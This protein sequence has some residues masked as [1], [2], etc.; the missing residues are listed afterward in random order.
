MRAY[1]QGVALWGPGLP[2]W[3]ASLP[4]LAGTEPYVARSAPPPVPTILSPTERRRTGVPVRLALVAAGQA[5]EMAGVPPG[6]IR[7][8]FA[9][10]NGDG[11]VVHAILEALS[12]PQG[13]VSPTQFHNSVHNAAAGYWTIATSSREAATCLGCHDATFAAALL[14]ALAE[15]ACERE[16]VLL[17]LYDAPL[18][19]PLAQKR[20][21]TMEFA[22]AFVL[23][24]EPGAAPLAVVEASFASAPPPAGADEPRAPSLRAIARDNPAARALPLLEALARR[25]PASLAAPYLDGRLDIAVMPCSTARV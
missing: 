5:S 22:A 4:V 6:A 14:K 20:H 15:L 25:E 3:E 1:V 16:P 2:G 21:T 18:P 11:P 23:S 8:V 17:C 24:P 19:S 12:D 10:S 7:S 13:D 9:S